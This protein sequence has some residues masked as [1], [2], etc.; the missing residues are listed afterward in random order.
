MPSKSPERKETS[1]HLPDSTSGISVPTPVITGTSQ[2]ASRIFSDDA[3]GGI[4]DGERYIQGTGRSVLT[5]TADSQRSASAR[6]RP[7]GYTTR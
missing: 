4:M 5:E 3:A 1:S 2:E 7:A 6:S